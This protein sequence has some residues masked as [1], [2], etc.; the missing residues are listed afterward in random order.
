VVRSMVDRILANKRPSHRAVLN[1]NMQHVA[2]LLK[3][4]E[5]ITQKDRGGRTLLH[6]AISCRSPELIRLLLEHGGDVSSVDTL[7]GLSLLQYAIIMADWEILSLMMEKRPAI[8]EEV[9]NEIK[10]L[11]Y[12]P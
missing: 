6:V 8:R 1:S 7:L 9:L 5:S 3:T 4:K 11:L 10:K 2:R 12:E